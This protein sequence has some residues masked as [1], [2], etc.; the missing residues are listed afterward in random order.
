MMCIL[1]PILIP[2]DA[3]D[4]LDL[5]PAC[6]MT[7]VGIDG[8]SEAIRPALELPPSQHVNGVRIA[9][10]RAPRRGDVPRTATTRYHW[11]A[12]PAGQRVKVRNR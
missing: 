7:E 4:R 9:A 5:A 11:R 1:T 6:F 2:A 10:T 3:T 8:A 12:G